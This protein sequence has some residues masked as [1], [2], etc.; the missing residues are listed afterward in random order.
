MYCVQGRH[1]TG[2]FR[3]QSG[4][5]DDERWPG[6]APATEGA[7]FG[8]HRV[9]LPDD[10]RVEENGG[11]RT[12]RVAVE[13]QLSPRIEM[14]ATLSYLSRSI[15]AIRVELVDDRRRTKAFWMMPGTSV[16]EVMRKYRPGWM[17]DGTPICTVI[18]GVV[19]RPA[20]T[21]RETWQ[22]F[23]GLHRSESGAMVRDLRLE[24]L[25]R[26]QELMVF[27]SEVENRTGGNEGPGCVLSGHHATRCGTCG[28]VFQ[29]R[30]MDD[31]LRCRECGR[32]FCGNCRQGH[33]DACWIVDVWDAMAVHA[34]GRGIECSM[35]SAMS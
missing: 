16:E 3:G 28:L 2:G 17:L 19:L 7:A 6:R 1:R 22:R 14:P 35:A 12:G 4:G 29:F 30:D 32:A 18:R 11:L 26:C 10:G 13:E 9:W 24:L 25:P 15:Q 27:P 5:S 8:S 33:E 31:V 23:G 34:S 20:A 21:L